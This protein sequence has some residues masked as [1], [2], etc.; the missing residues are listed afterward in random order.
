MKTLLLTLIFAALLPAMILTTDT[1][2]VDSVWNSDS[3]GIARRDCKVS[4]FPKGDLQYVWSVLSVSFNGG[5]SWFS[6][7]I[8]RIDRA[9][10]TMVPLGKK[11]TVT[12]RIKGGDRSNVAIR[13]TSKLTD[14]LGRYVIN[15]A[16]MQMEDPLS[17]GSLWSN[18]TQG[19]GGNVAPLNLTSMRVAMASDGVT[20]IAIENHGGINY[21]DSFGFIP[22]WT[23]NQFLEAVIYKEAGY[24]PNASGS[25]HE[26]E[27]ILGCR[28][29]SG[30]HR[31]NE[32]LFNS[33]GGVDIVSLDGGPSDFNSIGNSTGAARIPA[34]GGWL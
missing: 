18:N 11:K 9:L 16:K 27:I 2:T 6:D 31:W 19:V 15:F 12:A 1:V 5:T 29:S 4:F 20:H 17:V 33:G 28:T 21:D 7:S 10:D 25:N 26:L 24:N 30:N 14:S 3:A 13:V 34:D 22:G 32:F 8:I 23:S